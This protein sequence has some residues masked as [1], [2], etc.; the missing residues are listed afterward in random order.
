MSP[1][2][3][4]H[5]MKPFN[6]RMALNYQRGIGPTRMVLLLTTIGR[7]SGQ[8]HVTPLQFEEVDGKIYVSSARG[9]QADWYKNVAANPKVQVQMR[10]RIFE[11][12]AEAVTDPSRIADFLKLRLKRHPVMVRLIMT[13]F[14]GLPLRYTRADLEVLGKEKAL[15]IL[16]GG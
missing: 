9:R 5:R 4:Y 6:A 3:I 8:P 15:V 7:K 13:L 10:E 16:H 14:D 11:A 1:I 2:T 12:T